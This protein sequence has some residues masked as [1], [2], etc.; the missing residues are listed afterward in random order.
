M[1]AWVAEI[2][3]AVVAA[4]CGRAGEDDVAAVA[5]APRPTFMFVSG[6]DVWQNGGFAHSAAVWSPYGLDQAGLTIKLLA[7]MGTYRYLAGGPG[8]VEVTGRQYMGAL[9]PGWRFK[10]ERLEVTVFAGLDW[11]DHLL[12]PDDP[13]SS[14]RGTR[15]GTRVGADVWYEPWPS[16]MLASNTS[17]SSIGPSYWTRAAAGL[18]VLDRIRLGPEALAMGDPNYQQYRV[19]AHATGLKTKWFEWSMG[20]GWVTDS[21]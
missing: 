12:T 10:Y 8:G 20:A 21:D 17:I 15:Y 6:M 2:V 13:D 3:A 18:R 16:T 11:Q 7:G 5:D 1:R 14:V 19:G 9:M 4:D